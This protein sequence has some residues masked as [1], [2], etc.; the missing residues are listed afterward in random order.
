MRE[1]EVLVSN[2]GPQDKISTIKVR[3]YI[4]TTTASEVEHALLEFLGSGRY[5]IIVDLGDVDYISSAG[6]GVF[7]NEIREIRK[8]GG[9]LKLANMIPE[10]YE[11]FELFEFHH[12][13]R[14][15]DTIEEAIK[16]FGL[17]SD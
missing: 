1:I 17:N 15:H 16:E 14:A 11:V 9:D 13:L 8:K 12:I 5:D 10:V 7:M 2:T 6:W 4:D 3:G